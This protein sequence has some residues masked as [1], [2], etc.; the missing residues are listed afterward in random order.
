MK[1]PPGTP[2]GSPVTIKL[3]IDDDKTLAWWFVIAN[4]PPQPADSIRDPWTQH[5]PD[6]HERALIEHRR[7]LRQLADEGK[8]FPA[9]VLMREANF[10]RRAGDPRGALTMLNDVLD[11][12]GPLERCS[13][14][15]PWPTTISAGSPMRWPISE[16]RPIWIQTTRSLGVTTDARSKMPAPMRPLP[17]FVSR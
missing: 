13:T 17:R 16:R 12:T 2:A 1:I 8:P 4:N 14:F 3:R 5:I 6:I 9:L 11:T 10:M 15:A 7:S